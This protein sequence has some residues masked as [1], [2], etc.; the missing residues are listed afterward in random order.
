ME[1]FSEVGP[2]RKPVVSWLWPVLREHVAGS[3]HLFRNTEFDTR[4]QGLKKGGRQHSS[5]RL[6][7]NMVAP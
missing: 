6:R 2:P 5:G 7:L 3:M 1:L 4:G